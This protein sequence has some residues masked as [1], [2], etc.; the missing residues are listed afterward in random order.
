MR[1]GQPVTR[2]AVPLGL[3]TRGGWAQGWPQQC[4]LSER[5]QEMGSTACPK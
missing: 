5:V 3:I 2:F 1:G 4:S